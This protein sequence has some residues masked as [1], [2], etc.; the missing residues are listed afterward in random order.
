MM[1]TAD[2]GVA[3]HIVAAGTDVV[4][5]DLEAMGKAARQGH[6]DTWKS[7]HGPADISTVRAAV[8]GAAVMVRLNPL[9]EGSAAE[10]DDALARGADQ[11]MLPMFRE[12][13]VLARFMELVAGRAD[14]VPLVETARALADM[15]GIAAL[16]P[17]RVHIG[18]NDLHLDLGQRFLFEP[19]A[20]GHLDD[21]AAILSEAGLPFGIGGVA[22]L[23]EGLV[24][25]EVVLGE[26]VRLGSTWVILSRT[27]HRRTET[28]DD[29]EANLDFSTELKALRAR[30]EDWQKATAEEIETNRMTLRSLVAQVIAG[31]PT[32]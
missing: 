15:A 18:L 27:F 17:A 3:A 26:H 9:H 23:G 30:Y 31:Q 14:V 20:K 22:R 32:A 10:I 7:P 1:I 25:A 24:P 12:A 16:R 29:L 5:V 2:P 19:L 13:A 11:L 4:F 6:L 28:L 21:A 8:P